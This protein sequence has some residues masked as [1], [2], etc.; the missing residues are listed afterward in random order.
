MELFYGVIVF[1]I[2]SYVL[3]MFLL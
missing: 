1:Y 3:Y 2:A